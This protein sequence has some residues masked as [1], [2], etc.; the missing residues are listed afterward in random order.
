M[1]AERPLLTIA[2]PTFN[3]SRFLSLLLSVLEPQLKSEPDVE[4]L[5]SDNASTDDTPHVAESFAKQGFA[6]RYLRNSTNVGPDWNFLQCYERAAGKY[7][8]IMGDDDVIEPFGLRTVLSSLRAGE[9]YDLVFL[10]SRGFT[11]TYQP[12]AAPLQ[13]RSVIFTRAEDLASHVHVFFT[14]ISGI[15][16]NKERIAAMP[17][18]PFSELVGTG[19]IQL[20]WTYTALDHHRRSLA[21]ETPMIAAVTNN[22]GGYPLFKVFGANL[23]RITSE[24]LTSG[25]VKGRIIRGTLESFFPIYLRGYRRDAARGPKEDPLQVLQPVFGAYFHYWFFDYPIVALPAWLA[26]AWFWMGK[27][28]N[29]ADKLLGRP[30]LKLSLFDRLP[31]ESRRQVRLDGAD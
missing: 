4:V 29:R 15:I 7:L 16:V 18:R 13:I 6:F 9:E 14:F 26:T 31:V 30:L 2:I 21:I 11:G 25:K 5:I 1:P 17:H 27:L 22:S 23:G 3:R 12:Q 20:G 8:W 28:V 19:L 24:W 10:R